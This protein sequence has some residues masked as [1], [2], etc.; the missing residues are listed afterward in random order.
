M[1]GPCVKFAQENGIDRVR[2]CHNHSFA[3]THEEKMVDPSYRKIP[4]SI[5]DYANAL[6]KGQM[7]PSGIYRALVEECHSQDIPVTFLKK[8]IRNAYPPQDH[9]SL[10]CSNLIEHLQQRKHLAVSLDFRFFTEPDL[11]EMPS[12]CKRYFWVSDSDLMNGITVLLYVESTTMTDGIYRKIGWHHLLA[13][14][15]SDILCLGFWSE[16]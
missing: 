7:S 3:T 13:R 10:D 8:D 11:G 16:I 9:A 12:T 5:V 1:A 14:S 15:G 6:H 4:E 2:F